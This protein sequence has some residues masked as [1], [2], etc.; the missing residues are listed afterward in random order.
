MPVNLNLK[1]DKQELIDEIDQTD[2][3]IDNLEKEMEEIYGRIESLK[4]KS[5]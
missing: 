4:P 5:N 2:G 1:K 3:Q